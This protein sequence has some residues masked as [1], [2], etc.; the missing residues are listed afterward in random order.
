MWLSFSDFKRRNMPPRM[1][2]Q[3]EV[4]VGRPAVYV[5]LNVNQKARKFQRRFVN[6][7]IGYTL[8]FANLF[9]GL[10]RHPEAEFYLPDW[11]KPLQE[12][13]HPISEEKALKIAD[14][15]RVGKDWFEM[16]YFLPESSKIVRTHKFLGLAV[17]M[18]KSLFPFYRICYDGPD[19]LPTV[20]GVDKTRT[21]SEP[22]EDDEEPPKSQKYEV[23][24][25]IR[26][27]EKSRSLKLR[28]RYRCQ[29]CQEAIGGAGEGYAEVHHLR[30]LGGRHRGLDNWNNMLVL[31]PNHHAEFD[32][33][34][35]TVDANGR[36]F[37]H[38]SERNR[39]SG[40]RLHYEEGHVISRSNCRYHLRNL[41]KGRSTFQ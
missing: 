7:V 3:L 17:S 24:R 5:T 40:K 15:F 41:Y 20:R 4:T 2:P 14:S 28:Y 16:G 38:M 39:Y 31:C 22:P 37:L 19:R 25:K 13:G 8:K 1:L 29:I 21:P 26:D 10:P 35:A 33:R 18:I 11:E 27:S 34:W 6:Y 36:K 12:I 9:D 30:P 32:Y 23:T